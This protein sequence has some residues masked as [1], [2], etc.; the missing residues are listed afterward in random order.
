M[1]LVLALLGYAALTIV[2]APLVLTRGMWRLRF[3]RTALLLWHGAFL[4][5][6]AAAL[7]SMVVAVV[8][9]VGVHTAVP[10]GRTNVLEPTVIVLA[11]WLAL[12]TVGGLIALVFARAEPLFELDRE[13]EASFS[14]LLGSGFARVEHVGNLTVRYIDSS[15]PVACTTPGRRPEVIVSSRLEYA[16][17][18][19]ELRAVIEHERA[20]VRHRHAFAKRLALLNSACLPTV[21]GA[22]QFKRSTN[23]L[24]EL[25]ADDSAARVCGSDQVAAALARVA[26]LSGSAGTAVRSERLLQLP[27]KRLSAAG[28]RLMVASG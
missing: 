6:I 21:R 17:T 10:D 28:R 1:F 25:I 16:L 3:P 9:A 23:L 11:A 27:A 8:L 22:T 12:G 5:G 20:H 2:M 4:S 19:W 15:L 14:E 7:I 13:A 26:E 18:P 24:I